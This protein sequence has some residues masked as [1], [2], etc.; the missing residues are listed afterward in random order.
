MKN[1]TAR[2]LGAVILGASLGAFAFTLRPMV[3]LV[4]AHNREADVALF[5][6]EPVQDPNFQFKG[7]TVR[8]E[9]SP[10]ESGRALAIHWRG[11][12]IPVRLD[13]VD[14]RLPGLLRYEKSVRVLS[15]AVANRD[16]A[17]DEAIEQRPWRLFIAARHTPPGED[18]AS[19]GAVERKKWQ[20]E[21]IE[22]LPLGAPE[23]GP[24]PALSSTLTTAYGR[25]PSTT[26][27]SE[28]TATPAYARWSFNMAAL[29]DFERTVQ[30]AAAIEVTP[31]LHRPR[32]VFTDTGLE[33]MA[34]TWPAAGVS[35]L[36][37]LVG[38]LLIA[39]TFVERPKPA[40]R[41]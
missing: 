3:L 5:K 15:I 36:G 18:P 16:D 26:P 10:T 17:D 24:L 11:E 34:W 19:W 20:Y 28:F 32:N 6:I 30:Y 12:Q 1:Q 41:A 14:D 7:E 29:P 35:I 25:K 33:A 22:L 9:E 31:T 23:P 37:M 39:S 21:I 4:R 40:P 27:V 2:I 13:V 8:I 38:G